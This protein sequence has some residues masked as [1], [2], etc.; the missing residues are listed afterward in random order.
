MKITQEIAKKYT[1]YNPETG[2][3]TWKKRDYIDGE[4]PRYI[5]RFNRNMAGKV[6]AGRHSEGYLIARIDGVNV[7]LHRLAW[8]YHYGVEPDIIDHIN[9]VRNDNR[10][11][12]LRNIKKHE[13]NWNQGIRKDNKTGYSGLHWNNQIGKWHVR[14][15]HKNIAHHVGFFDDFDE[16]LIERNKKIVE[17]GYF[18]GHGNRPSHELNKTLEG[19]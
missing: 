11:E 18:D 8:I 16:A 19:I 9:G 5:N 13:N 12:N 2:I 7:K 1:D 17:L 10:I 3:F 4:D 14:L 15:G 6:A